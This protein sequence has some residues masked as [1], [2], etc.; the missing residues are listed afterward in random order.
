MKFT[1][2]QKETIQHI[3][4]GDIY[5]I[6]SYLKYFNLGTT[7]KFDKSEIINRFNTDDIP[8][9]YYFPNALQHK[10]AN[11][12]TEE[13][14][15]AKLQN[16]EINPNNYTVSIL[17]LS[18]NSGIK[19]ESWNASDYTLNFYKGVYVANS[20]T[21]ILEFLTLWQY[22]VSEMLILEVPH[23]FSAEVLG[24]FYKK[25]D[26]SQAENRSIN[27]RIKNI[28]FDT[29]SYD[30]QYYLG[31]NIYTLSHEHCIMCKEYMAKRIYP[32]TKL[33]IFINKNFTTYE[34]RTQN[35]A[36]FV[37]WL[38][39]FVSV[40]LTFAPYFHQEDNSDMASIAEEVKDIM[41]SIDLS[42][43][44]TEIINK[45]DHIIDKLDTLIEYYDTYEETS[46]S[47]STNETSQNP[48]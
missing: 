33:G 44:D 16:S 48:K 7:I 27:D 21:D 3:F 38:A 39:I 24:L 9:K 8:K 31:D 36:L 25:E 35:K 17:Q 46:T 43:Q 22:L 14:Y 41:S 12:L 23:D 15:L 37:A 6:T 11:M 13:D 1:K 10:Y 47:P 40:I 32:S 18:Y 45:L 34:E 20:F 28:N 42:N 5:D 29:F 19:H 2:H 26:Y 4:S 30:D